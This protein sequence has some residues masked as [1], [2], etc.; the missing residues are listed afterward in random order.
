MRVRN[1]LPP[2]QT[3]FWWRFLHYN[4][5]TGARVHH[6]NPAVSD[7]CHIC[8]SGRE[9]VGH[10]FW[11]CNKVRQFWGQVYQL[12]QLLAPGFQVPVPEL[13]IVVNPFLSFPKSLSPIFV[14]VHGF[15]MWSVWKLYLGVIFEGKPFHL[16][17]LEELFLS[18]VSSHIRTLF[19]SA[20]K[21]KKVKGF[22]KVWGESP[23]IRVRDS[24]MRSKSK[25]T[26]YLSP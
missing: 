1:I 9:T 12:L 8:N 25:Q 24:C 4:I 7:E 23:L 2:A 3:L 5:M 6:M 22:V 11:Y 18:F 10:L 20:C 15:A 19:L 26:T 14:T 13:S 21:G 16:L 17:A